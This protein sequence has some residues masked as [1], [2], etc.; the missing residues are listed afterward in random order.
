MRKKCIF[1]YFG[2]MV[3]GSMFYYVCIFFVFR[4][5][6]FKKNKPTA[7]KTELKAH[8]ISDRIEIYRI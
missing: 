5:L 3:Y 2:L 1:L 4:Q 8:I 6:F 7:T